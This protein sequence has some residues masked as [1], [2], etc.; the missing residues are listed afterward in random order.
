ML[1]ARATQEMQS[2]LVTYILSM[3]QIISVTDE[4]LVQ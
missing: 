3:G 2:Q 4:E 1:A